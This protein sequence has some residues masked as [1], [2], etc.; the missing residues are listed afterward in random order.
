MISRR[1]LLTGGLAGTAALCSAAL[2]GAPRNTGSRIAL[3]NL[4]TGER[5][6]VEYFRDGAYVPQAMA[7][8]E[9]KGLVALAAWRDG[10]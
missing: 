4:H 8:L 2:L 6:E 1:A 7:S 10:D 3:T 9:D 5:L